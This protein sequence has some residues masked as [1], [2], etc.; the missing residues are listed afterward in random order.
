MM[1]VISRRESKS[2]DHLVQFYGQDEQRLSSDV[3]QYLAGSLRRGGAALVIAASSHCQAIGRELER[4]AGDPGSWR[5]RLVVLDDAETLEFVMRDGMP[6]AELLA[7]SITTMATALLEQFGSLRVYGEMVGRLWSERKY[8]AAIELERIWNAVLADA[9]IELFCGYPIDVLSDDFQIPAV[10]P[11]LAAHREVVAALP[12]T[13]DEA[14]GKAMREA[15]GD[16]KHGLHA[17]ATSP[18]CL[19]T[20]LPNAEKTILR[21][22]SALPRYADAILLK[23]KEYARR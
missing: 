22:R 3:A 9:D 10:R 2:S 4:T 17:L 23:A 15:L 20:K 13:F 1:Y 11:L 8:A 7:S 16:P 14:I 19:G 18:F 21:L 6:N 5:H 12:E